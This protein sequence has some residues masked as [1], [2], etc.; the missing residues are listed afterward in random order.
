MGTD[1]DRFTER[2]KPVIGITLGDRLTQLSLT[3][4]AQAVRL[5]TKKFADIRLTCECRRCV[6]GLL[7]FFWM[8]D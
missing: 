6:S 4:E 2:I 5:P 7:M 8:L 3:A 1:G